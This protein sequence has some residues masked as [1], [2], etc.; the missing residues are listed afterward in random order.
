[1]NMHE[2]F[3]SLADLCAAGALSTDE[4]RE[5]EEHAAACAECA[6]VL[7]EATEFAGWATRTVAPDGPPS[8]H[9]TTGRSWTGSGP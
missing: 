9:P 3:E 8:D 2:R 6:T 4:R 5:V 1:M 7:R